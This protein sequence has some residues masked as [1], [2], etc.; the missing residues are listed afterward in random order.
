VRDILSEPVIPRG[1][2]DFPPEVMI[3]RKKILSKIER[4]FQRYGFD[5]F[6]TPAIEYLETLSGKYGEEAEN[7]LMWRFKDPWSERWYALRYDLTVPMA[8]YVAM[9]RHIPM[10]FKR[11]HIAPVWRH[12]EPQKGRYREFYQCDVDIVGSPYPE[13][14]AEILEVVWK[15]FREFGFESV[16]ILV[17]DRRIL[18]GVFEKELS[19]SDPMPVYRA[20]DKLDKIGVEGVENE[21][22]K[23]GLNE[24]LVRKIM[25]TIDL[26]GDP[27]EILGRLEEMYRDNKDVVEGTKF[28]YEMIS[29]L[30]SGINI[31]FDLSLVRGL[32][33]YTGPIFEAVVEK[34]RIGSLAGGGRYDDLIALFAGEKIPS[35]GGSIGVE[36]LIDAGVE[37][38]IFKFDKKT[39]TH[40]F[41]VV[42]DRSREIMSYAYDVARMLRE[43]NINVSIDLMRRSVSKQREYARKLMIPLII[44]IG[45]REYETSKV[46]IYHTETQERNE[47]DKKDLVDMIRKILG[48]EADNRL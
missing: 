5:P 31:V 40:V 36:R 2:R 26:R 8:R 23:I 33:Y 16:K 22:K 34:P 32:D 1:F 43:N 13:A 45:R 6:D 37:L 38:G 39:V 48:G 10:P 9:N 7:K 28:L 12:E 11:Y 41:I 18:R 15:V 29:Y 44:F 17:N 47:I 42:L 21:L 25:K 3:L 4:I 35:T 19:I 46:T 27:S 20:V 24:D 30:P 14:D